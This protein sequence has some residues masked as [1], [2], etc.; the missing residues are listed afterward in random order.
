MKLKIIIILSL[1]LNISF[2]QTQTSFSKYNN[3]LFSVTYPATWD[4]T[5][6]DSRIIF[7]AVEKR[8][9]E[10]DAFKE[11]FTLYTVNLDKAMTLENI[12]ESAADA[13]K[14]KGNSDN[15]ISEKSVKKTKKVFLRSI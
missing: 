5:N 4:T 14:Q 9:N 3:K 7:M 10:K 2:G 11:N 13:F 15:D 12:V 8:K 1:L 6:K